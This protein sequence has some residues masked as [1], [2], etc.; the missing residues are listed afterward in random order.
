MDFE[1]LT[2]LND[3]YFEKTD[4]KFCIFYDWIMIET[5]KIVWV[6]IGND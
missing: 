1:K 4:A 3:L 2:K 6:S 5:K